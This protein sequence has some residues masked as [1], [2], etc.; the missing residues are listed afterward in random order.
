MK[1]K[2]YSKPL[3]PQEM[4]VT[5]NNTTAQVTGALGGPLYLPM[6]RSSLLDNVDMSTTA[7]QPE[8]GEVT[9]RTNDYRR[10]LSHRRNP[11]IP[12]QGVGQLDISHNINAPGNAVIPKLSNINP[13]RD[14]I[15]MNRNISEQIGYLSH[16]QIA[17]DNASLWSAAM[18]D[19]HCESSSASV[20]SSASSSS[21]DSENGDVTDLVNGNNTLKREAPNSDDM[22]ILPDLVDIQSLNHDLPIQERSTFGDHSNLVHS[23]AYPEPGYQE[24]GQI[25]R[26]VKV[27]PRGPSVYPYTVSHH[28]ETWEQENGRFVNYAFSN[29]DS[30]ENFNNVD[31]TLQYRAPPKHVETRS[32][33]SSS[34]SAM[35]RKS[36]SSRRRRKRVQ[37]P[38]QRSAANMRERRRMCHLNVA[39]DHLKEH[40]PNVKDKKKLSRIQTLRAAIYYIHLLRD[41][42]N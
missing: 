36:G 19:C 17:K 14:D 24:A 31:S 9:S 22:Q 26:P 11:D 40:L 34:N 3:N 28:G 42:L 4:T 18:P 7:G 1:K 39:F 20:S 27:A 23:A 15:I 2:I 32:R 35:T 12:G 33:C 16:S 6:A 8:P 25:C 41:S 21:L 5:D 38:V 30:Y 13:K 29:C 10:A 37:T